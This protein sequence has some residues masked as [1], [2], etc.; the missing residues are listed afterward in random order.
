MWT[1][2]SFHVY[3]M[4]LARPKNYFSFTRCEVFLKQNYLFLDDFCS[5]VKLKIEA[6]KED[7][8]TS[9]E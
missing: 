3:D 4:S 1:L 8:R 6:F 7:E 9:V 2:F 5:L